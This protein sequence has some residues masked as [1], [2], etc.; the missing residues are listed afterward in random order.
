ML[1]NLNTPKQ[2]RV[3]VLSCFLSIAFSPA[4]AQTQAAVL[5]DDFSCILKNVKDYRAQGDAITLNFETCPEPPTFREE[6]QAHEARNF[7]PPA[8]LKSDDTAAPEGEPSGMKILPAMLV[9]KREFECLMISL[10][11]IERDEVTGRLLIL[12]GICREDSE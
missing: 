1:N 4:F 10:D 11:R 5:P 12:P 6:L 8:N 7:F 2:A 9:T 3:A